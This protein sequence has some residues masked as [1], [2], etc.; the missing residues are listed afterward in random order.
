MTVHRS[1]LNQD[2]MIAPLT[3]WGDVKKCSRQLNFF[4]FLTGSKYNHER[5]K[6]RKP[7]TF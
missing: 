5:F 7:V 2:V 6:I 1:I 3:K 4:E